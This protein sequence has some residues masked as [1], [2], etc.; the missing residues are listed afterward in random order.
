MQLLRKIARF[1]ASLVGKII[2]MGL[3]LGPMSRLMTRSSGGGRGGGGGWRVSSPPNNDIGGAQPLLN[4]NRY[5]TI[6]IPCPRDCS[7]IPY[8]SPVPAHVG[9]PEK[10]P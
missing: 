8:C 7:R 6:V 1:I 4:N 9:H 5:S 10:S 2:S 3:T